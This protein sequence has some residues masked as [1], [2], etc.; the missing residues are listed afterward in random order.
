MHLHMKFI[1]SNNKIVSSWLTGDDSIDSCFMIVLCLFKM[2]QH[3][4]LTIYQLIHSRSILFQILQLLLLLFS[5]PFFQVNLSQLI[6]FWVLLLL[7]FR[8][9]TAGDSE[10]E[11]TFYGLDVGPDVSCHRTISVRALKGIQN[12]NHFQWLN[13][14]FSSSNV[15]CGPG[16]I[17]NQKGRC[18][19]LCWHQYGTS[20]DLRY[21]QPIDCKHNNLY[22]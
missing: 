19:T 10:R 13:L 14:I 6:P 9:W 4:K 3:W 21:N 16:A 20:I 18:F 12:T 22:L 1:K 15:P 2:Q 8:K 17:P 7:L 11:F 5:C